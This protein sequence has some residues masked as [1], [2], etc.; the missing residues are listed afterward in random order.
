MLDIIFSKTS[1]YNTIDL[2]N[3]LDIEDANLSG[4]VI[5]CYAYEEWGNDL[6]SHLGG[7]FSFVLYDSENKYYFCAR[8]PLGVKSLYFTKTE[9]GY[10]FSS[11]IDELLNLPHMQK[12]PNLKSMRTML[13]QRTVD[14]TDTMYEGIYRLPPGHILTIKDGKE[15]LERY[16]YPE[17]IKINYEITKDEATKKFIKF[18]SHA[19]EKRVS[20]LD[21]TAFEVSGGL[22][23]SS[24]VSVLS[25][26]ITP[27]KIDSYS[28][29][30]KGL[31]CDEG[32][33]VDSILEKYHL[34]HQKISTSKL[35]YKKIYSLN[36]LYKI[37]PNWPITLTFAMSLPM[38]EKMKT[39]GK[40]IVITGQGGDHL[41]T[42]TPYILYDLFRR[43]K[44]FTLYRE[45]KFYPKP[46]SVIKAYIIKPLLGERVIDVIK[47]LLG[48]NETNPFLKEGSEIEDLSQ[49]VGMKNPAYQN[50]LDMITSAFYSTVM[51][52]NLF[53]AAENHFG[54]E[55]RHPYFD[56]ELVE[57][58]LS[59]PPEMKYKQRTIKWILRKAMDGILPDKIRDRKD[60]AE[61]SEPIRQQIDAIDL[62]A[63]LDDPY[64][65]KLGLIEQSLI[66]KYR[67]EYEDKTIKYIVILWTIINMEYWYRY[68]F[69]KGSL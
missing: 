63:L 18:F 26:S 30:F 15:Y 56:L 50:D 66:D 2:K 7:D 48:K 36:N 68:N 55:Y 4:N 38:L 59:L 62:G 17:K 60:K 65:V 54:I 58:A 67:Q 23:S 28:M 27:Y 69:E 12:K 11:N 42:G 31:E 20:N 10:K 51:D 35:D 16:W 53:H 46:W 34:H 3:K 25:Q 22:D 8:D 9:D 19:I 37:S 29:D 1:L 39:D 21:K 61:F 13:Y 40:R 64:I 45:L 57:F 14:Y 41:F 49:V 32:K 44:F 33:Y 47:V 43:F 5:L 6:L 24:V 52:G